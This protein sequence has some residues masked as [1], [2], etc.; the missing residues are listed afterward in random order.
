MTT[1]STVES[2]W[3]EDIAQFLYHLDPD[4]RKITMR[5]EK[6]ELK[7][8]TNSVS[9]SLTKLAWILTCLNNNLLE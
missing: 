3:V 9:S 8:I 7:I 1:K 2:T 5:H 4:T 6:I